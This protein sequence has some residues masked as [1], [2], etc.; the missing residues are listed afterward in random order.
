MKLYA[1]RD[2]L[3][4]YFMQPF[5]APTDKHVLAAISQSINQGTNNDDIAQSPHHFEV[6]KLAEVTDDGYIVQDRQ[7][8]ASCASLIRERVRT[9][10]D[11]DGRAA[12]DRSTAAESSRN[13]QG[14]HGD[15][16]ASEPPDEHQMA[17]KGIQTGTPHPGPRR[18][19]G[20]PETRGLAD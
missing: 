1:I 13:T 2:R 14:S 11:N 16:K 15:P 17:P 19:P 20:E 7:L 6:W 12:Q 9:I 3:L 18:V 10:H 4:D 8:I 5:A